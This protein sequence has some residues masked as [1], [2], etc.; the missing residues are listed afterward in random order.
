MVEWIDGE[1]ARLI[2]HRSTLDADTLAA[3][4]AGAAARALFD[5]SRE[6][7][8]ARRYEAAAGHAFHRALKALKAAQKD[9]PAHKVTPASPVASLASFS[10]PGPKVGQPGPGPALEVSEP[11]SSFLPVTVGRPSGGP[12]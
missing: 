11:P 4:R 9:T 7:T 10:T 1:I 5:P 2:A 6:A 12:N 3:D 8:L